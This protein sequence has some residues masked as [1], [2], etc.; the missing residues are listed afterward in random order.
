MAV[1]IYSMVSAALEIKHTP[2][3]LASSV[4]SETLACSYFIFFIGE[5]NS[6]M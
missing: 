4:F 6:M 2:L 1:N 3:V 5:K